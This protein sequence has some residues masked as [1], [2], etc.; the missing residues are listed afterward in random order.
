MGAVKGQAAFVLSICTMAILNLTASAQQWIPNFKHYGIREGLPSSEVYQITSDAQKNL[1][2]VTDRGVVRYDG[3]V[4]RVFDKKDS[5]PENSV[6]KVYKDWK[7]RIWFIAFTGLLS[8]YENGK[9][10]PYRYNS[11]IRSNLGIWIFTALYVDRNETVFANGIDG[12]LYAIDSTGRFFK[13]VLTADTS[14]FI[15]T[16][17]A[18]VPS[19][20]YLNHSNEKPLTRIKIYAGKQTINIIDVKE[21]IIDRHFSTTK[22]RNGDILFYSERILVRIRP[23]KSYEIK[24]FDSRILNVFEDN[25]NHLWIGCFHNGVYEYDSTMKIFS[26]YLTDLSVSH[27]YGDYENGLWLSTLENGIFYLPSKNNLSFAING[28]VVH[29]KITSLENLS[30]SVLLFASSKNIIYRFNNTTHAFDEINL[31]LNV[32]PTLEAIN[33]LFYVAPWKQLFVA[34]ENDPNVVALKT[35]PAHW[36][37]LNIIG[38]YSCVRFIL[39]DN[40]HIFGSNYSSVY[41]LDLSKV[42]ARFIDKGGLHPTVLYKDSKEQLL[43]GGLNGLYIYNDSNFIPFHPEKEIFQKRVTDI[44]EL[45]K[46]LVIATRSDGIFLSSDTEEEIINSS[47]GLSSDNINRIYIQNNIIWASTNKGLNKIIIANYKPLKFFIQHYNINTGL[48]SEEIND[49]AIGRENIYIAT[50]DGIGLIKKETRTNAL[51]EIPLYIRSVKINDRDTSVLSSYSLSADQNTF[52]I[53]YT[54]VSFR[55]AKSIVYR[56][57][58]LGQDTVWRNTTNRDLQFTNLPAG[59]YRFQLLAST[60]EGMYTGTPPEIYFSIA[61]SFYATIWFRALVVAVFVILLSAAINYR[62]KVIK[63]KAETLNEMNKKFSELNLN[64]LR[65]QMNPHFTFNVLNS[66]QYYIAKRDSESAQIYITKFS[67]LIRMILDQSRTEFISL[68][69]EIRMLTLYIEL[70]EL[71]FEKKFSYSI[72]T[73]PKLNT[74]SIFIPGMLIQPFVENS[75]RHGIRFKKGDAQVDINFTA[76]DSLLICTIT[77]NG[78]GREEAAKLKASNEEYKSVGTAIVDERIQ[79]LS[80]LFNGKLKNYISDLTDENGHPAG[81]RVTVEIPFK[82]HAA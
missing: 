43:A 25:E 69:E 53:S 5:L 64:A 1:W 72:N 2:F 56:Y 80:I 24:R 47:D 41:S 4:F 33:F 55:N 38:F 16:D 58:L 12:A 51:A 13:N 52:N 68:A 67:R 73:D 54:A 70:E 77:D 66:I 3:S 6:I 23:D 65:S 18:S 28:N 74:S 59:A 79:A 78:I 75:I 36:N 39:Q 63:R 8:Y 9:I 21:N 20:F 11:V 50:N 10:I 27:V 42:S 57:R 44:G 15:I 46:Y 17:T 62:I 35:Y 14:S 7:G 34:T 76:S 61:P 26:H 60:P 32:D 71:R 81:T 45:D 30:D 40:N 37:G 19:T 82:T 31:K 22:L 29:E 48:L 49:F